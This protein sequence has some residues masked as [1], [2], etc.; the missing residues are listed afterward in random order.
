ME[1]RV[2][3]Q[4]MAEGEEIC[5]EILFL[6]SISLADLLESEQFLSEDN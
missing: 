6:C 2:T 4:L 1:Y 5:E 3:S